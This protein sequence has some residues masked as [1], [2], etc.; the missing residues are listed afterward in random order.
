[1]WELE[2][3][4]NIMN[5]VNKI[6]VSKDAEFKR[7]FN[8][9]Y[10]V[11]HPKKE[12]YDKY[13]QLMQEQ[14]DKKRSYKEVLEKLLE[15]PGGRIEVSFASKLMATIDSKKPIWDQYVLENL[16]LKKEWDNTPKD[17]KIEKAV[18]IYNRIERYYNK[19]LNSKEGKNFIKKFNECF[20]DY[21]DISD[22]KKLDFIIWGIR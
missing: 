14:K 20:H 9:F 8:G 16:G 3:Y 5:S 18:E 1:M 19:F 12:W 2:K 10:K 7:L 17:K 13:Y 22:M 4:K 15:E 6:D 21:T 11:R